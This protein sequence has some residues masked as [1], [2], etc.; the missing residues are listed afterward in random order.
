[1]NNNPEQDLKR[2]KEWAK[3]VK[4]AIKNGEVSPFSLELEYGR[5]TTRSGRDIPFKSEVVGQ[6]HTLYLRKEK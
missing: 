4:K 5:L 3:V 1:M 2:F 6:T